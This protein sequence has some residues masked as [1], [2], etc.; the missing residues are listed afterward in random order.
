MEISARSF[1]MIQVEF[2]NGLILSV[3]FM[4]SKIAYF[5][6][7]TR[8]LRKSGPRMFSKSRPYMKIHY[9]SEKLIFDEFKC[10]GVDFN[11]HNSFLKFY[12]NNPK[13]RH[14]CFYAKF[15]N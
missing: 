10:Q 14:F 1:E 12:P 13:L 5:I 3:E 11:Y 9:M 8:T 2:S 4:V 7:Q 15:C 6:K